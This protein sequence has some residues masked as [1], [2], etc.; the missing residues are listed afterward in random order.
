M[1][2]QRRMLSLCSL[3]SPVASQIELVSML[4]PLKLKSRSCA[5][6]PTMSSSCEALISAFSMRSAWIELAF[7]ARTVHALHSSLFCT[8]K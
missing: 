6:P 2:G 4:H 7:D 5:A 3:V 8:H 1:L